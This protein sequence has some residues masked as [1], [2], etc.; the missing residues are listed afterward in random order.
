MSLIARAGHKGSPSKQLLWMG[1]VQML[2]AVY[3]RVVQQQPEHV[4]LQKQRDDNCFCGG[5]GEG[6][7]GSL[8]TAIARG[9][10]QLQSGLHSSGSCLFVI[11]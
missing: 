7:G 2:A 9:G 10:R 1:H 4:F 5:G 3:T 11:R 6:V 8:V